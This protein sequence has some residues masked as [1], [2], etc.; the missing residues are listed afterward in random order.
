MLKTSMVSLNL[1]KL[2]TEALK[3]FVFVRFDRELKCFYAAKKI[4]S[5]TRKEKLGKK[6][7]FLKKDLYFLQNIHDLQK[8]MF[9]YGKKK[10]F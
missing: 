9:L 10:L 5:C 6:I 4:K 2:L 1:N 3:I 8:K 7:F